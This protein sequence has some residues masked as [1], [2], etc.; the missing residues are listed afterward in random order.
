M[1]AFLSYLPNDDGTA[2]TLKPFGPLSGPDHPH[3]NPFDS[4]LRR[5]GFEPVVVTDRPP[6]G[7]FR[8]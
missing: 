8:A 4:R 5:R 1:G 3:T 7:N 2:T 6:A